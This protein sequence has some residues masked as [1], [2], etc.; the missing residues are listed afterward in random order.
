[1]RPDCTPMQH[2]FAHFIPDPAEALAARQSYWQRAV[3]A[4]YDLSAPADGTYEVLDALGARFRMGIIA[5]QQ[6]A[7][8]DWMARHLLADYFSPALYDCDLGFAKPDPRHFTCALEQADCLPGRAVMIGDRLDNDIRPAKLLGMWT[9]RVRAFG[10]Y[11]RF[12]PASP[13][14]TPHATIHDIRA[15]PAAIEEICR[16]AAN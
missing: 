9:I 7:I 4:Y 5:N 13:E 16:L 2:V 1:M 14:E 6:A 11:T 3:A 15:L 8:H 10:D 12:E